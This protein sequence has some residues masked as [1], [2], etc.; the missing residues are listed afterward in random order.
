[1]KLKPDKQLPIHK[2]RTFR[3]IN[4]IFQLLN[5]K[6]CIVELGVEHLQYVSRGN[7]V[8]LFGQDNAHMLTQSHKKIR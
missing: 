4:T 7:T 5:Y 2:K 8:F 6:V 1:M 3:T